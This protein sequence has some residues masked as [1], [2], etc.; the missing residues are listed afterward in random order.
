MK[1]YNDYK[2]QYFHKVIIIIF[3][4][5]ALVKISLPLFLCNNK[6]FVSFLVE[7]KKY[8]VIHF[9]L[10]KPFMQNAIYYFTLKTDSVTLTSYE[11]IAFH[12][13]DC[14]HFWELNVVI[15][16]F[17][18]IIFIKICIFIIMCILIIYLNVYYSY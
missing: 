12:Y 3:P 16:C 11:D 2:L 7:E 17:R 15:S 6:K 8:E 1:N 5:H 18:N 4:V 14:F 13:Q 10:F 9:S